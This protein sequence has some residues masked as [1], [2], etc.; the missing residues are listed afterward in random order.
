MFA[1][2][3][4]LAGVL[5]LSVQ[6]SPALAQAGFL[7]GPGGTKYKASHDPYAVRAV[8]LTKPP[9][10]PYVPEYKPKGLLFM[11]AISHPQ[12]ASGKKCIQARY[13]T[14]E[15]VDDVLGF[16]EEGLK[17]NG[18]VLEKG[19]SSNTTVAARKADQGLIVFIRARNISQSGYRC[20]YLIRYI[21]LPAAAQTH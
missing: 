20:E 3:A 19:Q 16:Y 17:S 18:W 21:I 10:F 6:L 9:D 11:D 2:S 8:K 14:K 4:V 7:T 1:K 15:G 13:R 5:F 12:M